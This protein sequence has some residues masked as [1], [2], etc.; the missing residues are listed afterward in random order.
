MRLGGRWC[1]TWQSPR[2]RSWVCSRVMDLWS[3]ANEIPMRDGPSTWGLG[4]EVSLPEVG[5]QAQS[6]V[7]RSTGSMCFRHRFSSKFLPI[8]FG[9]VK[10]T[11][12]VCWVTPQCGINEQP[13]SER[14]T[15]SN[16]FCNQVLLN[17]LHRAQEDAEFLFLRV[18]GIRKSCSRIDIAHRLKTSMNSPGPLSNWTE[19]IDITDLEDWP[20]AI[21]LS[22]RIPYSF[23]SMKNKW[24]HRLDQ[25]V[26]IYSETWMNTEYGH[27]G[28]SNK[29]HTIQELE[30]IQTSSYFRPPDWRAPDEE[31]RRQANEVIWLD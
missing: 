20:L 7:H 26:W 9:M 16:C 29:C 31:E 21:E 12:P 23:S 11:C 5:R 14:T 27:I 2:L 22:R 17:W 24:T 10:N 6:M 18:I 19:G 13:V 28:L 3:L 30:N 4:H 1:P 8:C 25:T 15:E